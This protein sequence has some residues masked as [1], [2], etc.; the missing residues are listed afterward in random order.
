ML[1]YVAGPAAGDLRLFALARLPHPRDVSQPEVRRLYVDRHLRDVMLD[2]RV[3][4]FLLR[5]EVFERE[6]V[7]RFG[8]AQKRRRVVRDEACLPP[9]VYVLA[10][11]ADQVSLRDDGA[12][13]GG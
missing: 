4:A 1:D 13:G 3:A 6:F 10:G 8:S 11:R 7:S 5:G 12:V 2:V 9:F